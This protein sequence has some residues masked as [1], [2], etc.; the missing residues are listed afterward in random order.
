MTTRK[1]LTSYSQ[2]VNNSVNNFVLAIVSLKG[3]LW[4]TMKLFTDQ[5]CPNCR[6][7]GRI[8]VA[9]PEVLRDIRKK[10]G[11]TL[12]QVGKK[13]GFSKMYL[14]DIE[15]GRRRATPEIVGAY[16]KL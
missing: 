1:L 15:T 5:K 2:P 16:Q 11:L 14:S 9:I 8:R 4:H 13:I 3:I 7:K 6:G 12:E 10:S